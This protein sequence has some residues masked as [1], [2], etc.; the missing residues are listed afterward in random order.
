MKKVL[1]IST[2]LRRNSNS[3]C[4][5]REF[6]QGAKEAGN[7]VDYVTLRDKELRFCVGCMSCLNTQACAIKDDAA[8]LVQAIGEAQVV[9]FATPIYYYEMAGQMKTLLDRC[10]PLFDTDY[11]F[12]EVYL[13]ATAADGA[14]SAMDGAVKGLEGWVECFPKARLAG[15]LRGTGV[16]EPGEAAKNASLLEKARQMGRQI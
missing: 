9:V 14:D 7:E 1:I 2:S 12:R 4:L 13:L 6:A 16:N 5:A 11:A 3:D 15:V 8:A 10:N